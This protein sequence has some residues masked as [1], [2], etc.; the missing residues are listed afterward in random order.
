MII[1]NISTQVWFQ[2]LVS[3][4]FCYVI[5]SYYGH[6]IADVLGKIKIDIAQLTGAWINIVCLELQEQTKNPLSPS[7]H[8]YKFT[9]ICG[10]KIFIDV[11]NHFCDDALAKEEALKSKILPNYNYPLLKSSL[12]HRAI[13]MVILSM[14]FIHIASRS[15]CVNRLSWTWI[16]DIQPNHFKIIWLHNIQP[17]GQHFFLKKEHIGKLPS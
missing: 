1:F 6:I 15:L 12:F 7:S 2:T 3:K 13:V 4:I 17:R 11:W 5:S 9:H 14:Q 10:L 8:H 16:H